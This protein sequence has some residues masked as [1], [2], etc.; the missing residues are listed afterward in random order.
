[1]IYN[2]EM[3]MKGRSNKNST[4]KSSQGKSYIAELFL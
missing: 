3:Y 1:M 4:S 2:N